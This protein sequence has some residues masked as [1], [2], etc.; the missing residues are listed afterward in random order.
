MQLQ[1][2]ID[3]MIDQA[4]EIDP[5]GSFNILIGNAPVT[6]L[7]WPDGKK[8]YRWCLVAQTR[9]VPNYLV[10]LAP[11]PDNFRHGDLVEFHGSIPNGDI[12]RHTIRHRP[13]LAP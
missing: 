8:V 7:N 13:P 9:L 11:C 4:V 5:E 12:T 1:F 3:R 2:L 10:V 6:D